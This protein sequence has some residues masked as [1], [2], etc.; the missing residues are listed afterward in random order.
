MGLNLLLVED[1]AEGAARLAAELAEFGHR[2]S[3]AHDGWAALEAMATRPF[4]AVLLDRMMPGLDGM[5]FL[6]KVREAGSTL[7]IIMVTELGMPRDRIE[8]LEAG[9]DDYVVK[10]VTAGELNARLAAVLRGRQWARPGV[11]TL[12]AGDITINPNGFRA[13]R[14]G[15]ALDLGKIELKLLTEFVRSPD[16]VLTRRMLLDRVWG[17]EFDPSSNLLDV[18]VRRLRRKLGAAGGGDMIRTVRGVG[19]SL[20]R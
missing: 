11:D 3:I 2:S 12:S 6:Q 4:D 13:W 15:I 10:P 9:A 17:T 16:A 7:P 20:R 14:G 19:Y 18:Y 8:G 1:D 5:A